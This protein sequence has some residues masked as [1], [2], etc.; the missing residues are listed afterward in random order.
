MASITM[1][2]L[3]KKYGGVTV[4]PDLNLRIE[5]EEFIVLVGPSG[6]GKS[7]LLRVLAGLEA[8]D[9]GE[10]LIGDTRVN[11]VP[12]ARRDIAMVFQDYALYPHMTVRQN[13]SFAL[14]MRGMTPAETA[15]RVE[16]AA[17]LLDIHPYL[18]RRPK[19][20][21]GGQ[22]Q[23][24]AMGRAIVRDPKVFLFDEPLSNLDAKLRGQVRAEIKTLSRKLKTTMVFVTHDQVEA[25][26]MA[27]RIVVMKSGQIQ[28]VGTPE[29]VYD[30]PVNVFVASFIG[31]PSM[32]FLPARIE[33]DRLAL[34]DG[35]ETLPLALMAE[36]A[37]AAGEVLLGIRPE[38][39]QIVPEGQGLSAVIDLV[40][41]LGSDT[42][43]HCA[44]AGQRVI[45][46]V[47][48]DIRPVAGQR[49]S[50]TSIAGKAH[51]FDPDSQTRIGQTEG[52][53]T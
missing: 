34:A 21:S 12:A 20:L 27:D 19:A 52:Q 36:A 53:A 47:S 2:N 11:D 8:I 1:R 49:I 35:G 38:H 3:V 22:R 32:N 31:A 6:C 33:G 39:F 18:D 7:T 37:P 16:D 17:R 51:L 15:P 30:N 26:T 5:D 24:V 48:P 42:L 41:P 29:E 25:M 13:M 9:G 44:L 14:E 46:R 28:Q 40:E 50:L 45:A 43:I 23:R 10:L 4:I